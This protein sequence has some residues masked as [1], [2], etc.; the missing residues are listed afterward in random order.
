MI[1]QLIFIT[2]RDCY[3]RTYFRYENILFFIYY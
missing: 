1:M 3:I 2:K